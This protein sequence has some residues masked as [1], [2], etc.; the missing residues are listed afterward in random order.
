M[1]TFQ[2][3]GA[4]QTVLLKNLSVCV[5][6]GVAWGLAYWSGVWEHVF[7]CVCFQLFGA[8]LAALQYRKGLLLCF[9]NTQHSGPA[10]LL[11]GYYG[12]VGVPNFYQH[13]TCATLLHTQR[14]VQ[15]SPSPSILS[16]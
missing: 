14:R 9:V 16:I 11:T 5:R 13:V 2:D 8:R 3:S 15:S 10:V 6:P 12:W 4:L 7:V 1:R